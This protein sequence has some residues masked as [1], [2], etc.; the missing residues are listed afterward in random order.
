MIALTRIGGGSQY[1]GQ[2]SKNLQQVPNNRC[3]G[4]R[5]CENLQPLKNLEQQGLW[6]LKP[7]YRENL[8]HACQISNI[9]ERPHL[10]LDVFFWH[11]DE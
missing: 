3:V 1:K 4:H 5:F 8:A 6:L 2:H 9:Y 11:S 10:N 7:S